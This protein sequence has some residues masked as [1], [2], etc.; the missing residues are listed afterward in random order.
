MQSIM[1]K[2]KINA[3]VCKY[4]YSLADL[5]IFHYITFLEGK[6]GR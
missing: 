2:F 1:Y 6:L 3:E 4:M 5:N